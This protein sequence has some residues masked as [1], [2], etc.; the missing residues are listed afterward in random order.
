MGVMLRLNI[1]RPKS[2]IRE[3][4]NIVIQVF[5]SNEIHSVRARYRTPLA[6][7]Y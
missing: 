3:P 5:I 7:Q 6:P 1:L 4:A 2:P